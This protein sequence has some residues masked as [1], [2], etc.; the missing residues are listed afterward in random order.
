MLFRS[1]EDA[2]IEQSIYFN[3]QAPLWQCT[4]KLSLGCTQAAGT[5]A[6]Q[7]SWHCSS[8][9][10]AAW[11]DSLRLPDSAPTCQ[12]QLLQVG[13]RHC[14]G[15]ASQWAAATGKSS[16]Y[17]HGGCG[18]CQCCVA[19]LAGQGPGPLVQRPCARAAA[20]SGTS[21]SAGQPFANNPGLCHIVQKLTI[22]IMPRIVLYE[23]H[24]LI[25]FFKIEHYGDYAANNNLK[26]DLIF[27]PM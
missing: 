14:W 8:L 7:A 12:L 18:T 22:M 9:S 24:I 6:Q 21:K 27:A 26:I 5:F 13:I 3:A 20:C 2:K 16:A 19:V 25:R 10:A 1:N 4:W 17:Y 15:S 11:Q 23:Q